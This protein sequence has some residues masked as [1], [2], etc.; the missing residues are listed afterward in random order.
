VRPPSST[1]P[2]GVFVN[3]IHAGPA[4]LACGRK[5]FFPVALHVDHC[6][7]V[8]GSSVECLIELPDFRLPIVSIFALGIRVVH[9]RAKAPSGGFRG[10]L[11]HLQIAIGD[12]ECRQWPPSYVRLDTHGLSGF[13]VN[14]IHF[15]HAEED[16]HVVAHFELRDDA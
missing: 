4:G 16:R 9:D 1:P 8:D 12:A 15:R 13:V 7:P 3:R 14:E 6:P 5:N 11:K 10:P 2:D